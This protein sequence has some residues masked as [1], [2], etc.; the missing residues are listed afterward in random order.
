MPVLVHEMVDHAVPPEAM[1]PE[2]LDRRS[3][4]YR[5]LIPPDALNPQVPSPA[6]STES[7][8]CW[9]ALSRPN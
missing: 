2:C 8:P 3:C 4:L 5:V 1:E 6:T 7:H 9:Q